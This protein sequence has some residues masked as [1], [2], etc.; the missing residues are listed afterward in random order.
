LQRAVDGLKQQLPGVSEDVAA[1]LVGSGF[2]SAEGVLAADAEDLAAIDGIE[3]SVAEEILATAK[4][5]GAS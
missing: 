4:A 2:L 1:K 3:L 5:H